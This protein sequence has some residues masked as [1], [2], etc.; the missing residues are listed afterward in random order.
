MFH[1]LLESNAESRPKAQSL[2]AATFFHL[3]IIL[4]AVRITAGSSAGV[5]A[6]ARDTIRLELNQPAEPKHHSVSPTAPPR[7]PKTIQPTPLEPLPLSD[8]RV[9][10]PGFQPA[11]LDL[12]ALSA[13]RAPGDS[14]GP[15]IR[16]SG[17]R[18]VLGVTDVDVL[19][20]LERDLH[21]RYPEPLRLA[22]VSGEVELEYVIQASGH[23]DPQT[24][25]VLSSSHPAFAGSARQAVLEARFKPARR[26]GV[27]VAVK[28]RQR[29]R[30]QSE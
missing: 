7:A 28:V 3:L 1:T 22:R 23:V 14:E 21:P 29:I 20:V 6:I 12:A 15:A 17:S 19:P 5:E 2:A 27:P 13:T 9:E 24:I 10:I 25:V 4:C 8:L 11:P 18:S 30:F 16:R 26:A